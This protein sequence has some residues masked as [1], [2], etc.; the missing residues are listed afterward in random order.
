MALALRDS[1]AEGISMKVLSLCKDEL[2]WRQG[3]GLPWGRNIGKESISIICASAPRKLELKGVCD[4]FHQVFLPTC[5]T[6][7][8]AGVQSGFLRL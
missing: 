8:F 6:E 5:A 7:F 2:P 4:K 1:K 3:T